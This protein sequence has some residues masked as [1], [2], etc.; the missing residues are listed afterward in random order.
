M[1]RINSHS[2]MSTVCL[3][4]ANERKWGR[5]RRTGKHINFLLEMLFPNP[6]NVYDSICE[7]PKNYCSHTNLSRKQETNSKI[8]NAT[9]Y[10]G[11]IKLKRALTTYCMHKKL[12][13][14]NS[15][16]VKS[17]WACVCAC[18]RTSRLIYILFIYLF[19]LYNLMISDLEEREKNWWLI[20]IHLLCS[21]VYIVWWPCCLPTRPND[22][23][24]T[25]HLTLKSR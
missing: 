18:C 9:Q 23:L 24:L 14:W 22:F 1:I 21:F 20:I 25:F 11:N 12:Y 7:K 17:V 13:R 8:P 19:N 3:S 5:G 6:Y 15:R 4:K 16:N 2:W 10:C